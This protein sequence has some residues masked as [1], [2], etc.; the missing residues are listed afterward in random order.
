MG[1]T[2]LRVS[3]R[4]RVWLSVIAM[5]FPA[6]A[7]AQSEKP[8]LPPVRTPTFKPAGVVGMLGLVRG[9][10][11]RLNALWAGSVACT[12]KLAL[13]DADANV[14]AESSTVVDPHK[15]I[16]LDVN[17]NDVLV[18]ASV[19]LEVHGDV[20]ILDFCDGLPL[21]NLELYDNVTKKTVVAI[22]GSLINFFGTPTR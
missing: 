22:G 21:F 14:L 9:H 12:I 6:V 5:L 10:T 13:V 3:H 4:V 20:H 2:N 18:D 17:G 16:F 1:R 7:F 19:R 8:P 15:A 11:V